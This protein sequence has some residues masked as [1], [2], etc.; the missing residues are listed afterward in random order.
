METIPDAGLTLQVG[1]GAGLQSVVASV[2]VAV[3]CSPTPIELGW[4]V[5]DT[6]LTMHSAGRTGLRLQAVA[7]RADPKP[8][9]S[10]G[11]ANRRMG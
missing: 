4:A 3:A 11:T 2:A 8:A 5:T 1:V 10:P 9:A 6:E 7:I